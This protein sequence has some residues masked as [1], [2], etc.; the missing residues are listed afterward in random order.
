MGDLDTGG[1]GGGGGEVYDFL[2]APMRNYQRK[3]KMRTEASCQSNR[4][5][6]LMLQAET[7]IRILMAE[8]IFKMKINTYHQSPRLIPIPLV[9]IL[10]HFI[11]H[12]KLPLT[13]DMFNNNWFCKVLRYILEAMCLA[14]VTLPN[15]VDNLDEMPTFRKDCICSGRV[16]IQV[17]EQNNICVFC[18]YYVN[19][20]TVAS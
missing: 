13:C 20:N 3:S 15:V 10:T 2:E 12:Y 5:L 11:S 18:Q 8:N 14:V 7:Q 9:N 19:G 1:W 4:L 17:S 16:V 6:I